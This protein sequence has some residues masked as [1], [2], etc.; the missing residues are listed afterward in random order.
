MSH[1]NVTEV[2]KMIEVILAM[3]F[4]E[5]CLKFQDPY[6]SFVHVIPRSISH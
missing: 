6:V 5:T 3:L 2:G 4:R 1:E